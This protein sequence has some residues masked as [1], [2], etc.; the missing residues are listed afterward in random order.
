[1]RDMDALRPGWRPLK[2]RAG[3]RLRALA[4]LGLGLT[5]IGTGISA[6]ASA[7]DPNRLT[8]YGKLLFGM[9]TAEVQALTGQPAERQ[10]DGDEIIETPE[11]IA[12]LPATRILLLEEGRLASI[13][14]QWVLD[15]AAPGSTASCGRLFGQLLGQIT[16]RYGDPAIGAN[17]RPAGSPPESPGEGGP[18]F[19]ATSFWVFP[20][21]ASIGLI[22]R[23]GEDLG[24]GAGTT[25][26]PPIPPRDCRATVNYK[27]P[28]LDDTS[29]GGVPEDDASGD[30]EAP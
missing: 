10:P 28:P 29:E 11:R 19:A 21:G 6:P 24:G 17:P 18:G 14:F 8:G 9:T 26:P 2:E 30:A 16:G 15:E 4:L 12:G 7:R 1:M 20:D 25:V 5:L 23:G 13:M 22:V 3:S 27:E